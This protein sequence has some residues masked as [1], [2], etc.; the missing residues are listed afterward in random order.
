MPVDSLRPLHNNIA[1]TPTQLNAI[2]P[3]SQL[4]VDLY[5]IIIFYFVYFYQLF[6]ITIGIWI[7]LITNA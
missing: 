4:H 7:R 1:S 3:V 6:N 2:D 5:A